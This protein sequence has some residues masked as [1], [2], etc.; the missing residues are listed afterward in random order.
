LLLSYLHKFPEKATEK[1]LYNLDPGYNTAKW[2]QYSPK[3][4][5][6]GIPKKS[7]GGRRGFQADLL[8]P[9]SEASSS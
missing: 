2:L 9:I 1:S 4:P 7:P 8:I 3:I 6:P 5:P